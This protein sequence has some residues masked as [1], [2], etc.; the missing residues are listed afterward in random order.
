MPGNTIKINN[1]GSLEWYVGDSKMEELITWLDSNGSQ[2]KAIP[3]VSECRV[4]CGFCFKIMKKSEFEKHRCFLMKL[5]SL[6]KRRK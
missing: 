5:V 6:F 4:E 1:F 2:I 3:K